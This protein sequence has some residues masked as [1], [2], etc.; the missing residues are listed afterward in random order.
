MYSVVMLLAMNTADPAFLNRNHGCQG[1]SCYG[2]CRGHRERHRSHGCRGCDGGSAC[3]GQPVQA[4]VRAQS[5]CPGGQCVA[6]NAACPCGQ[7]CDCLGCNCDTTALTQ[8]NQLR[9]SRGLRPFIQDDGL[10]RAA[11]AAATFRARNRIVGHT[12]NDF[13]FVPANTSARAAGCGALEPSWGW[14]TCCTYDD[15]QFAGAALV[16]GDD[17]RNYMQLYVR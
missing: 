16:K 3:Y 12:A 2:G 11:F 10:V 14:G 5:N 15:A 7:Q 4:T 6:A 13:A 1:A 8:V 17:G 9:Q